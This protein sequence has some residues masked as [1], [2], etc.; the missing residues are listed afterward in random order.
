M[1]GLLTT[2]GPTTMIG[3]KVLQVLLQAHWNCQTSMHDQSVDLIDY[4]TRVRVECA[5]VIR[6]ST[7]GNPEGTVNE[8]VFTDEEILARLAAAD[9]GN[10]NFNNVLA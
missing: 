3:S 4:L 9:M 8:N 7:G 1:M 10:L 6:Q 2:Y 5:K